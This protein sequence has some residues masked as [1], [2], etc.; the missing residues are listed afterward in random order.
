MQSL[1]KAKEVAPNDVDINNEL[2]KLKQLVEKQKKTERELAK[3]MFGGH[4]K[5]EKKEEQTSK[6][7]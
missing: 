5:V 6:K 4:T 1:L 7:V 2:V 3:R